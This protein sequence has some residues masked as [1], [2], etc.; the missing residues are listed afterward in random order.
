MEKMFQLSRCVNDL[1]GADTRRI[2][3]IMY[4]EIL[5]RVNKIKV[6]RW[7]NLKQKECTQVINNYEKYWGHWLHTTEELKCSWTI[8][9]CADE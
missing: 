7:E 6:E 2:L 5:K 8:W 3:K 9:M 4:I 1:G